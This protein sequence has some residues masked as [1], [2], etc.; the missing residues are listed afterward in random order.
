LVKIYKSEA[1]EF[2]AFK[3]FF[4]QYEVLFVKLKKTVLSTFLCKICIFS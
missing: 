4:E 3:Q 1:A 2:Q